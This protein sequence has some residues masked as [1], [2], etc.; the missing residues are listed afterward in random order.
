MNGDQVTAEVVLAAEG[1]TAA[2][3]T[4]D[5]VLDAVG[6]VRGHVGLEVEG[7]S[8][9]SRARR[10]LVLATGINVRRGRVRADFRLGNGVGGRR[11]GRDTSKAAGEGWVSRSA[12]HV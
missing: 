8:E 7:A 5:E 1:A 9:G 10:A 4:A 6:V 2:G 12:A 11:V 3:V